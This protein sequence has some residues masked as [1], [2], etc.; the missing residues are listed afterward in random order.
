MIETV[1]ITRVSAW[2]KKK[3]GTK[4]TN[5]YGDFWRVGIQTEEHTTSAGDPVWIN[6]FTKYKP[7]W[8]EGEKIELEIAEE[9]YKGEAQLKF[10]LPKKE[11]VLENEVETLKKQLAEKEG[12]IEE[13][14]EAGADI[15]DAF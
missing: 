15:D 8:T 1:T 9:E 3:D 5:Q 2:D 14:K 10:R 7:E 13:D 11:A 12:A 6:G 4:L